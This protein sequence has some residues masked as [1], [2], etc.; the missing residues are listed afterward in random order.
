LPVRNRKPYFYKLNDT[1]LKNVKSHPYLG[2][3]LAEDL[4]WSKHINN[5]SSKANKSLGFLRRNLRRWPSDL[6][7]PAYISLV[8]SIL[9]YGAIVWD[10]YSS[11]DRE[12]LEKV[13]RRAAR[14][15]T[16]DY[17][18]R[19]PGCVTSMLKTLDLQDLQERRKDLRLTYMFKVVNGL[20]KAM[21]P[22]N[23]LTPTRTGCRRIKAK[24]FSG[25]HSENPVSAHVR[26][27]SKTFVVPKSNYEQYTQS[28]FVK[29]IREWNALD[30]HVVQAQTVDQFKTLISQRSD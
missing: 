28:F 25:Y 30:E 22:E 1:I 23:F 17:K 6:K 29:T 18:S 10:P 15:I 21:P 26:N 2:I 27:N 14:F 16:G 13:Q 11:T 20:I 7:K 4:K 8:R 19:S 24:A 5:V 12:K 3:E 9:D